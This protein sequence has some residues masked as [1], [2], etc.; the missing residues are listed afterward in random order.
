[1][2]VFSAPN[3][4]RT[5]WRSVRVIIRSHYFFNLCTMSRPFSRY[6]I[7]VLFFP[8][9]LSSRPRAIRH[10]SPCK[11]VR[12]NTLLKALET[13]SL[14]VFEMP[15]VFNLLHSVV[16]PVRSDRRRRVIP[17]ALIS[18]GPSF[19]TFWPSGLG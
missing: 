2:C 10:Y 14:P 12:N 4:C 16:L 13:T 6:Y 1:M 15:I 7:R 8:R 9:L 5:L 19:T 18:F 3:E 11:H 17:V